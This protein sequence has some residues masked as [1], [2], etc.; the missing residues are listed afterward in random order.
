MLM[1]DSVGWAL[2]HSSS[3]FPVV[4]DEECLLFSFVF[5]SLWFSLEAPQTCKTYLL[6][7]HTSHGFK[8]AWTEPSK[9]KTNQTESQQIAGTKVKQTSLDFSQHRGCSPLISHVVTFAHSGELFSSE[10]RFS[11]DKKT[12]WLRTQKPHLD[13]PTNGLITDFILPL[14]CN[15]QIHLNIS[16]VQIKSHWRTMRRWSKW[17][18]SR[19]SQMITDR[20]TSGCRHLD[21]VKPFEAHI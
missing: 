9:A 15:H 8:V 12:T 14:K 20:E 4:T 1:L 16:V 5:V 18:S 19:Q 6:C 3:V 21:T 10:Q 7:L 17:N 2:R 11:W 13:K